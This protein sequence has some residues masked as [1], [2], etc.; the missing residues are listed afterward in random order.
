MSLKRYT[1]IAD[2]TITTNSTN[3]ELELT[4]NGSGGVRVSGFKFPTTDGSN[5]QFIKTDGAKTLAFATAGATLSHSDI[6]DA[7]T[8]IASSAAAVLNTYNK[9]VYRSAKYFI[10]ITDATNSRYELVECNV[11]HDG[12]NAYISTFGGTSSYANDLATFTADINGN[13]V[14]VFATTISADSCVF[15]F[16]R[17]AI[18]I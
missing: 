7:T 16:Q 6:A 2:N 9:T 1:A 18:D 4:G 11:T 8:T 13:D 15:K 17:T 5:G 12:T 14:R 10:S 3:A